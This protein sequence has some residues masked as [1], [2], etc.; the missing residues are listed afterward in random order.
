MVAVSQGQ[1]SQ[2]PP[3]CLPYLQVPEE[4]L[5]PENLCLKCPWRETEGRLTAWS[6]GRTAYQVGTRSQSLPPLLSDPSCP[7]ITLFRPPSPVLGA[8]IQ[9]RGERMGGWE[10]SGSQMRKRLN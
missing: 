10:G 9:E 4:E 2:P 5:Y 1:L 6:P 3:L 8:A 7:A